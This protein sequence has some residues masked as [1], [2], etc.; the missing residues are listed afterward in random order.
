MTSCTAQGRP[1]GRSITLYREAEHAFARG[2]RVLFTA[3]DRRRQIAT[4]ELGT[5]ETIEA[6]GDMRVHLE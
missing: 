4:R 3:P 6:Q 2:D 1:P 5:I